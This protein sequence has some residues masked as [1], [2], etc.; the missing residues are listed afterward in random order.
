MMKELEEHPVPGMVVTPVIADVRDLER[1]QQVFFKHRPQ[2]IFHAAAHKHVWLMEQNLPDAITNNVM[3]TRV[4]V[5]LAEKFGV[6]RFVMISSDKAVNP[7]SVMGVTKRIAELIVQDAAN[8]TG[9]GF[10]TVRFGNV[11]GSR[12]S[13]VPIFK[14]QIDMGGP[15]TVTHPEVTRYFMTIPE[16]VHLVLQAGS[17]GTGGEVFVLD[18]GEQLKV[19]DIARDVI[20]FSGHTE[21]EIGIEFT[22]LKPGEKMYEEL[23]YDDDTI[24]TTAHPMISVSRH[25]FAAEYGSIR[26]NAATALYEIGL[27]VD[28]ETLINAAAQGD[29]ELA[30]AII[31]R[32]VPA[33]HA[34]DRICSGTGGGGGDPSCTPRR[35]CPGYR[36]ERLR[37]AVRR[38]DICLLPPYHF[39]IRSDVTRKALFFESFVLALTSRTA[40]GVRCRTPIVDETR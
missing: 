29:L 16:A 19:V 3:G 7:T 11:L 18:M 13:V 30:N 36:G 25:N 6:R 4:L 15:V 26:R 23:F 5:T 10:V 40:S 24:E 34:G 27:G 1:M 22:G 2:I 33:V 32:I 8:R 12:G 21:S 14:H 31:R 9:R 35:E 28:V 37:S 17:I 39:M 20:R 38:L